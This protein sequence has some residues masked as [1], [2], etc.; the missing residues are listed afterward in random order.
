MTCWTDPAWDK[1]MTEWMRDVYTRAATVSC[2]QY[3][4]DFDGKQ[5]MTPVRLQCNAACI[6]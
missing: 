4:A 3:I 6:G 5:R 2:G 1:R